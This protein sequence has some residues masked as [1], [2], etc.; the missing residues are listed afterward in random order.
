MP[1]Q[2]TI[3][4]DPEWCQL[5][6][7]QQHTYLMISSHPKI[8]SC[9][10]LDLPVP[11]L[12]KKA[13]NLNAMDL[14]AQIHELVEHRYLVTDPEETD[15][16]LVRS[17]L[18]HDG[19]FRLGRPARRIALEWRQI[20]SPAIKDAVKTELKRLHQEEPNAIG[21]PIIATADADL[22]ASIETPNKP[23]A[24]PHA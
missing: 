14:R 12:T 8:N 23:Q 2:A 22:M 15:E 19:M 16:I 1:L 3:W 24:M 18:R 9:G 7:E 11:R 5:T 17:Y 13:R 20:E 10:V 6:R 21:W 4:D